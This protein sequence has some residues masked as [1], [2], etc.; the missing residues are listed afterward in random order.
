VFVHLADDARADVVALIEGVRGRQPG[1]IEELVPGIMS[2]SDIQRV[3][4]NLLGEEVSIRNIDLI[5]EA[6]VDVGRTSK[7]HFDLT[8]LVRQRL[9]HVICHGLRA[10]RD[11]LDVLSLHPR[12]EGQI[13]EQLRAAGGGGAV[14]I[15]PRQ[16]AEPITAAPSAAKLERLTEF[17]QNEVAT[18][19][20]AGVIVLIQ[21]HG[22]PVYLKSFGVLSPE[23]GGQPKLPALS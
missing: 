15:E 7:D 8:E 11:Q 9:S 4:Q 3:L 20:L 13:A 2:V 1:L 21:Q 23:E 17:F 16:A 19:K 10:G 22:R 18:G 14:G 6:L 12:I 5:V